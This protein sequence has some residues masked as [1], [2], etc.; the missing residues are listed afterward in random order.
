M[1]KHSIFVLIILVSL[2]FTGCK[3]DFILP[4]VVTPPP[5]VVSFATNVAPIFST[6][7]KCTECHKPGGVHSPD[8]TQPN[9]Y[10][11]IVPGLVNTSNP[12]A[13]TLLTHPGSSAHT[14]RALT[15]GES[16]IILAWITQGA[17]D[18]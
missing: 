7:N 16:S 1:K 10:S 8:L 12:A 13:S 11:Q 2:F 15:A 17:K 18:N 9:V 4:E 14:Q 5:A 6:G 3:Y